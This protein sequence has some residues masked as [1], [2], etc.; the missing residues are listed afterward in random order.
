MAL[1]PEFP[2]SPYAI[3]KPEMRWFPA[4]EE[5]RSTAYEKLLPP[6]V[7]RIREEVA[8]WRS[9]DYRGASPTSHALLDWWFRTDHLLEQADG[10]QS[11]FRYYFAQREGVES[12]IWLYDLRQARDKYDLLRFDAYGAVSA[13]MFDEAWPRFVVKMATGAGKTKVLSLLMAWSY[14]HKLYESNSALSRNFL[15]IAPNIIVLDRL[16]TDFDGLHIFFNDPVL[17]ENGHSG[18]NWRDDFQMALHI[19][20]DVR[21]VRPVGNL[22]LTNIHRVYLG[23]VKEPSREDEDL[24]DNFLSPFGDRPAGKTTD[25]NTDLGEIVRD[26]EELTWA[27]AGV[28]KI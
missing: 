2:C 27:R 25:S 12:V 20:D 5:L 28:M 4:A 23:D 26:I 13:N 21:V 19:Q 24:R 22:F 14:F 16:R 18:R 10:T 8:D 9:K 11:E 15:L 17:P 6:L 1:H 7:A 3:L